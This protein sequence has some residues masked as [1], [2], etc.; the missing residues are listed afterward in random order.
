MAPGRPFYS[1]FGWAYDLLI[2]DPVEPW[3]DAVEE[4]LRARAVGAPA[5]VLDA[6]CGTGRHAAELA[7]RGHEV[8]LLEPVPELLEQA[9]SRCPAARAFAADLSAPPPVEVDAATCRGVLNDLVGDAERDSALATLA[10]VLRP[11]GIVVLDVRDRDATAARYSPSWSL[12]RRGPE[13]AFTSHGRWDDAAGVVRVHERHEAGGRVAE[14]D[15]V[16]RPWTP[17]EVRVRLSAAGF[18]EIAI[19]AGAGTRRSDRLLVVATRA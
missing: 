19:G 13:V 14:F 9:R 8:V 17:D 4:A 6:G 18:R 10:A 7:R 16:M 11:G 1:E 3:V 12:E 5:R 15:L 2:A